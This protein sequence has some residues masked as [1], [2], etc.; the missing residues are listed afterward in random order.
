M[1]RTDSPRVLT[2][3]TT[4][5]LKTL[6]RT[7]GVRLTK[8]LGQHHLVDSSVIKRVV[9]SCEL[10]P[11]DT[12]VEIGAGLGALTEPLAQRVT[13]VIAVEVDRSICELL[14]ARMDAQPH[15][16]VVCQDILSFPWEQTE[17]VVVGAIPYSVT[18]PIL[19]TLCEHRQWI[20]R[21]IIILQREVAE[22]LL[23][24]P[25]TKAYGR[26]SLLAQY[27][28]RLAVVMTVPRSAFF[29]QP[30]IDSLCLKLTAHPTP[31]VIVENERLF[32][33]VIKAAFAQRRKSLV[34]CLCAH[35]RKELD[36][37]RCAQVLQLLG[38][39]QS[40]RGEAL[41]L[42]QFAKLSNALG[43][44]GFSQLPM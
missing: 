31:P 27:Y 4:T 24:V 14:R 3:L 22:R 36:R 37:N 19:V 13:R 40:V 6:L 28:W 7:H 12:V 10:S 15:V 23:A 44:L 11:Q 8:R 25:G 1:L 33:D 26:L 39:S 42:E 17:S 32:F 29:P 35:G 41:S 20:R 5:E 30:S 34:N 21:A 16:T 43:Q 2:M 38:I 9:E 18:S